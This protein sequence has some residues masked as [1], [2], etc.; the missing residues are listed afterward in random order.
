MPALS[1]SHTSAAASLPW[2]KRIIRWIR[3]TYQAPFQNTASPLS[4][5]ELDRFRRA[6]LLRV[7]TFT[8]TLVASVWALAAVLLFQAE[9][10]ATLA[11]GTLILAGLLSLGCNERGWVT[12]AGDGEAADSRKIVGPDQCPGLGI[13]RAAAGA[14][15][16]LHALCAALARCRQFHTRHRRWPLSLPHAHPSNG[17]ADLG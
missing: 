2:P 7:V 11:L 6:A 12:F 1:P 4:V 9:N 10:A 8:V 15:A 17:R 5:R 13:G 3:A 16:A 14:A